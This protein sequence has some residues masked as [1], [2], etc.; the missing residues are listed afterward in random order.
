MLLRDCVAGDG[1]GASEGD[2]SSG[3][4]GGEFGGPD[5]SPWSCQCWTLTLHAG[6]L[7]CD[8]CRRAVHMVSIASVRQFAHSCLFG[9]EFVEEK[10]RPPALYGRISD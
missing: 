9:R 6:R 5:H 4:R 2:V 10:N 8:C 3:S 7:A 1:E